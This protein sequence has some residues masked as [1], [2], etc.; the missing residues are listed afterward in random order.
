MPLC[1]RCGRPTQPG[2][3][4]CPAC[5]DDGI[6]RYG[7]TE[8]D[9]DALPPFEFRRPEERYAPGPVIASVAPPRRLFDLGPPGPPHERWHRTSSGAR[10]AASPVRSQLADDVRGGRR[11]A[12]M[13]SIVVLLIA[14]AVTVL[15]VRSHA[16]RTHRSGSEA[17][18]TS[19]TQSTPPNV[20][21]TGAAVRGLVA[22][23]PAAAAAPHAAAVLTL[24][25]RYFHA[26]NSHAYGAYERL[27]SPAMRSGL[28]AAA[29]TAGF[30]TS[31]D[32]AVTLH[33]ISDLGPGELAAVMSFTSHQQAAGS[34]TQTSCTTWHITLYMVR[35]GGRYLL[36]AP[37][38]GY[39]AAFKGCS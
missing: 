35:Q 15:V 6:F 2:M 1:S 27:F 13:A 4:Y 7:Q 28:S 33:S 26:I 36:V 32:S 9:L 31:H 22:I 23:D 21:S 39:Q 38:A 25:N 5:G 20:T 18:H 14:A 30:G 3:D 16:A 19:G 11:I 17:A 24:L 34:A 12:L 37:P 8:S 10:G 29:F